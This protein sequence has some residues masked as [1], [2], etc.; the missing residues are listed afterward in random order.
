MVVHATNRQNDPPSEE[1][2]KRR[3]HVVFIST[4]W[5]SYQASDRKFSRKQNLVLRVTSEFF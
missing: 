1:D 3:A 2:R 5:F 4:F